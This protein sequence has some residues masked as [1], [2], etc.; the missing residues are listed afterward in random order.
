MCAGAEQY[1]RM[2]AAVDAR[3]E[4]ARGESTPPQAPLPA[5]GR[6]RFVR[7]LSPF[8]FEER[9]ASH[10]PAQVHPAPKR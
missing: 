7:M 9:R 6:Y 2:L 4:K 5:D 8:E 1:D 10:S 3:A